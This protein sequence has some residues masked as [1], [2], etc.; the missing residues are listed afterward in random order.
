MNCSIPP[1]V[2]PRP[3]VATRTSP[4]NIGLSLLATVSANDLG[5]IGLAEMT[6]RL[7]RTFSTMER[8]ERFLKL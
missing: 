8:L 5:W 2:V 6:E 7:E 1:V 3:E 4:T